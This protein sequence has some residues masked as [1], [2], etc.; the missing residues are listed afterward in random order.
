MFRRSAREAA[1][2]DT[3]TLVR[4]ASFLFWFFVDTSV[5]VALAITSVMAYVLLAL[6]VVA[7]S[8]RC[9][10][11]ADTP[12]IVR[13]AIVRTASTTVAVARAIHFDVARVGIDTLFVFVDST[14][15]AAGADTPALVRVTG[16]TSRI[17]A[18]AS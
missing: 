7:R 17:I 13:S 11:D 10:A 8:A 12:T 1:V 14:R 16:F 5:A 6:F 2:A 3:P 18:V 4:S 15:V 9:A